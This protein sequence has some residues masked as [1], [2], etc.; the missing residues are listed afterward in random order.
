MGAAAKHTLLRATAM[1]TA[2][3]RLT[4]RFFISFTFLKIF[5]ESNKQY[6][7]ISYFTLIV[8]ALVTDLP[9]HL[10]LPRGII[11]DCKNIRPAFFN[12]NRLVDPAVGNIDIMEHAVRIK[13]SKVH[14]PG[15]GVGRGDL[16]CFLF[17]QGQRRSVPYYGISWCHAK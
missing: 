6:Q 12:L 16:Y 8:S 7:N 9:R 2:I 13:Q 3:N 11:P 4:K 15:W 1:Q 5:F 10:D 17:A 14:A